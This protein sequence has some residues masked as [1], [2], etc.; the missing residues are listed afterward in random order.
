MNSDL[1]TITIRYL[2]AREAVKSAFRME[3]DHS[4]P[5]AANIYVAA[6]MPVDT[7]RLKE[8]K[9]LV[10][11]DA[12]VFSNFRG[13]VM[14]P[15]VCK[16][17]TSDDPAARWERAQRNYA[18][19]KE[20]FM[21]SE[22]LA[23]AALLLT[24][25]A[26]DAQVPQLA[27]RGRALYL[28]M[29]KEHPF[30]TGQEDSVFSILLAQSPKSDDELLRDAEECYRLL[31]ARFPKSNGLQ[32]ASHVLAMIDGVPAE[33]AGRVIALY[34][35]LR[36]AGAKYGKEWELPLLSAFAGDDVPIDTVV[37]EMT[38]V[39]SLLKGQSGY[40]GIFGYDRKTRMM[41]A[42]MLV[43]TAHERDR[44]GL[45]SAIAQQSAVAMIAA[46]QA[47]LCAMIACSTASAS[48]ASA[49]H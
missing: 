40:R 24:D 41:H 30:L 38:E 34:D 18:I 39:D 28:R 45:V 42:A 31:D 46:Q 9:R 37:S 7:E 22:Y 14:V 49:A 48:A 6:G 33:K 5:V 10:K 32:S 47:M 23:L 21:R 15:L 44:E 26:S 20:H 19:L 4:F 2:E 17:A 8:L 1:Q 3:N 36:G 12:G 27:A 29:K 35:A 43:S 16:L 13:S 11:R 25:S